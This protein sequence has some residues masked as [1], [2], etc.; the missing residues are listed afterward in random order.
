MLTGHDCM[1]AHLNRLNLAP[2]KECLLCKKPET[3]MDGNDLEIC[4]DLKDV[5][6]KMDMSQLYWEAR[7]RM[8]MIQI[9][10]PKAPSVLFLQS[11]LVILYSLDDL[12]GPFPGISAM[13]FM[14]PAVRAMPK[15][16]TQWNDLFC[17]PLASMY[18]KQKRKAEEIMRKSVEYT[19]WDLKTNESAL[20]EQ[21][22]ATSFKMQ[23]RLTYG[24]C[25]EVHLQVGD[26]VTP[27]R[28]LLSRTEE[29]GAGVRFFSYYVASLKMPVIFLFYEARVIVVTGALLVCSGAAVYPVGWDNR[30][31]RESCGNSSNI[32]N[33]GTCE[34][35]WSVYLLGSAVGLLLLCFAMSFCA[36]R[37]AKTQT[38]SF[39]NILKLVD[40]AAASIRKLLLYLLTHKSY[41]Y[42]GT[43]IQQNGKV[44]E[45][46]LNRTKKASSIYYQLS[47][48]I[49]GKKEISQKT[50]LQVYK[51]VIEPVLLYGGESWSVGGRDIRSVR[52]VEM[53][54]YRRIMG[55]TRRDRIRNDRIRASLK[56]ESL[57]QKLEKKQLG[58]VVRMDERRKPKQIM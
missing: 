10:N 40:T 50:K 16:Q 46:I 5:R 36:S 29:T 23:R 48:T 52:T 15:A 8:K 4:E 53:K 32:Y 35:S 56:Q 6:D 51:S 45:E 19:N 49:F 24:L 47:G 17:V 37:T 38:N 27:T 42:L 55:K 28:R 18:L 13:A 25:S 34:L 7:R 33:L 14:Y 30:E 57:E 21:L 54:C 26:G 22:N 31:V 11:H 20:K 39:V 12:V 43:I 44:R 58:H 1:S 9:K 2:P 41:E 3:V